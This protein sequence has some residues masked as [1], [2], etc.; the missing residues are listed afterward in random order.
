MEYEIKNE[1]LAVI[2]SSKG[3]EFRSEMRVLREDCKKVI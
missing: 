1:K 3:G 2:I